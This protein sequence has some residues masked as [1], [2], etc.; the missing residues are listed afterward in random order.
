MKKMVLLFIPFLMASLVLAE[1]RKCLA[2]FFLPMEPK[3]PLVLEGIWGNDTVL[4]RGI[5]NGLEDPDM[6]EWSYWDGRIVKDESGKYYIY[7][8]CGPQSL[9]HGRRWKEASQDI[10]AVSENVIKVQDFANDNHGS[11]IVVVP[12][13]GEAIDRTTQD[14]VEKEA[15]DS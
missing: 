9:P 4:P 14:V 5:K 6:D 2:D 11:K 8:S 3:G 7:A 15:P 1:D 13:D 10:H 12:F